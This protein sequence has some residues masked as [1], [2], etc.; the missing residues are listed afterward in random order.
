MDNI[1]GYYFDPTER[2][3]SIVDKSCIKCNNKEFEVHR[4]GDFR[5]I[6]YFEVCKICN[7]KQED[8]NG[9]NLY[10]TR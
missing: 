6:I 4:E 7:T 9:C 2:N 10:K 5:D 1:H 3:H 8:T